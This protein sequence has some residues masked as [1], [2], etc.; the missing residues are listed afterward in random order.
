MEF[1]KISVQGRC[2]GTTDG[3]NLPGMDKESVEAQ[4]Q[5]IQRQSE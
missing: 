3:E 1:K 2:Y 4:K 5:E